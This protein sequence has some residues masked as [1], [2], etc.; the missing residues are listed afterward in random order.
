MRRAY[1]WVTASGRRNGVALLA[2]AVLL[3]VVGVGVGW[4]TFGGKA[5]AYDPL[6]VCSTVRD[7]KVC[8]VRADEV[9]DERI[10]WT[11][12]FAACAP[13]RVSAAVP[14]TDDGYTV[15]IVLWC[16]P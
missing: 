4:L 16:G 2:W 9:Q 12:R 15:R 6:Y 7:R 13:Q 10:D 14:I 3:G 5:H 1:W 8:N 11:G